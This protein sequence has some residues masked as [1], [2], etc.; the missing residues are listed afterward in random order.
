MDMEKA[1]TALVSFVGTV[2]ATG[3]V[4]HDPDGFVVPVVDEGWIDLGE[5]YME[6]CSALGHDP[7]FAEEEEGDG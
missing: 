4:V 7:V 2:D 3:G 1:R 6:A 5:A